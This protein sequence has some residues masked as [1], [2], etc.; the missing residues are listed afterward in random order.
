MF[1]LVE[2]SFKIEGSE[3]SHWNSI[4]LVKF[5]IFYMRYNAAQGKQVGRKRAFRNGFI[6]CFILKTN[7]N[8]LFQ[9][10]FIKCNF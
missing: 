2:I 6:I 4:T 10:F 7:I 8:I 9:F 5:V 1:S 3:F